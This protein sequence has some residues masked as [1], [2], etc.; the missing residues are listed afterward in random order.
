MPLRH[1]A[2]ERE[3]PEVGLSKILE[4]KRR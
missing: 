2:E 4:K 1:M 3:A